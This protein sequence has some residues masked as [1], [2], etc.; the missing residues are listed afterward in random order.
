MLMPRDVP[1]LANGLRN[2]LDN[3]VPADRQRMRRADTAA[4]DDPPLG[5]ITGFSHGGANRPVITRGSLH[6]RFLI[7][8]AKTG[9]SQV[10]EGRTEELLAMKCEVD[11]RV[12]YYR[13]HPCEIAMAISNKS[14]SYRP[15]LLVV[16][17]DGTIE[18]IEVKRTP[19]DLTDDLREKLPLVKEFLRRCDIE[20]SIRYLDDIRGSTF[21]QDNV[22]N[23]FGRRAMRLAP[24][25]HALAQL[26]RTKGEPIAWRA[27][28]N[29][30]SPDNHLIGNACVEHLLACGAFITDL[31]A[32]FDDDTLLTPTL[33]VKCP[34][35]PFLEGELL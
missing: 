11:G 32:R 8:S 21:R 23:L 14:F 1:K 3:T 13:T 12:L 25:Q 29:L 26:V 31:D 20:F 30:V 18:I 28:A 16:W 6:L 9:R 27:L 35:I 7:P 19:A 34:V 22:A 24:H 15:D 17:R 2:W 5:S 10:G 4:P 33:D